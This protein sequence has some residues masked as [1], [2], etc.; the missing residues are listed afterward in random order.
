M[1]AVFV[2]YKSPLDSQAG[3]RRF[4]PGLPLHVFQSLGKNRE[5][6]VTPFTP[7]SFQSSPESR[8][9]LLNH[10]RFEA[11]HCFTL[12]F[13]IA[14][15][16]DFHADAQTV[17]ALVGGDLV[18]DLGFPRQA[19]R[20]LDRGAGER[21]TFLAVRRPFRPFGVSSVPLYMRCSTATW[22]SKTLPSRSARI[23]PGRKPSKIARRKINRSRRSKTPNA[24][25]ISAGINTRFSPSGLHGEVKRAAAGLKGTIP[26]LSAILKMELRSHLK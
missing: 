20:D 7:F 22:S 16:I 9:S 18:I 26:S 12:L 13:K 6:R 10:L 19:N 14:E 2:I 1:D 25:R 24:W 21:A 8:V 5:T 4:D 11:L 15:R 23:S 3:R 17:P